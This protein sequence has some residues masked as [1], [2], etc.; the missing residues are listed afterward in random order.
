MERDPQNPDQGLSGGE[1]SHAGRAILFGP[2][3]LSPARRLLR[4]GDKPVRLGSRALDILIA[5]TEPV[6]R[7]IRK[8]IP[9]MGGLDLAPILERA[10]VKG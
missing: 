1:A 3:R 5:L 8:I 7:P 4:E 6:F 9:P 10:L 2:F